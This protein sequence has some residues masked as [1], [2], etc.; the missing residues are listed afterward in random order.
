MV[1]ET[2]ST[3]NQ[4]L[5]TQI[6][7]SSGALG[8]E[9]IIALTKTINPLER[10][11]KRIFKERAKV[12]ESSPT[13]QPRPSHTLLSKTHRWIAI[14]TARSG[15]VFEKHKGHVCQPFPFP[16][17]DLDRPVQTHEQGS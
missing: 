17:M 5:T 12:R 14:W 15:G 8:F 1:F 11:L 3:S 10:E 7:N 4:L 13:G 16:T 6:V 2:L 9:R